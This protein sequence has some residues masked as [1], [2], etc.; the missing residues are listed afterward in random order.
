MLSSISFPGDGSIMETPTAFP[1][2]LISEQMKVGALNECIRVLT[3]WRPL[4]LFRP[5]YGL[6]QAAADHA[7]DTGPSGALGHTGV[8]G[9]TMRRR[10][11]RYGDW[12]I[13]VGENISYGHAHAR[14]IVIQLIVDDGVSSRG[15]RRN[16]M[17]ADFSVVGVAIRR[18]ARYGSMC[19]QDFAGGFAESGR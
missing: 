1:G 9:S 16:V 17:Q 12:D 2:A 7:E 5:S 19:V 3:S 14:E 6:S 10:I 11:E 18:H 4:P 8:D 15:H 13:R